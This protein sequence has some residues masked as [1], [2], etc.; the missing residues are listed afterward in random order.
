MEMF[1]L[2]ADFSWDELHLVVLIFYMYK[3]IEIANVPWYCLW[4]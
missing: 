2:I 1:V 4:S 3:W